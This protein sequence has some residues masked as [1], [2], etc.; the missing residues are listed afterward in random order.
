MNAKVIMDDKVPD[1]FSNFAA[2][3]VGGVVSPTALT[4]GTMYFLNQNFFKVRYAPERNWDMLTDEN[5]RVFA[6][7]IQGDSRL[8]HIGWM[9]NNTVNNRRKQGV[10]AKIARSYAS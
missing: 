5:G 2:Q 7:P 1:A 8:G 3:P 9:G 4:Y 6:K 10:L